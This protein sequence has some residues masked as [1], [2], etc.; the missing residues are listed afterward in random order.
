MPLGQ[1]LDQ[2][3]RVG[4]HG[5]FHRGHETPV[6]DGVAQVVAGGRR[7]GVEAQGE[8]DHEG[9]PVAPL[10]LEDAVVAAALDA[11]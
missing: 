2:V 3:D 10:E 5:G 6:V 4:L 7:P 11:R 9:L 8:V 1:G